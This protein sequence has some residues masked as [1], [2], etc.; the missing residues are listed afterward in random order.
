MPRTT[1]S[2]TVDPQGQSMVVDIFDMDGVSITCYT[3]RAGSSAFTLPTT[4]T[5]ETSFFL[6]AGGY[7]DVSVKFGSAEIAGTAGTKARVQAAQGAPVRVTPVLDRLEELARITAGPVYVSPNGHRWT[8]SVG[9]TGTVT[10][11][12]LDA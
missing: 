8:L 6:T 4:I 10:A 7:Y 3:A 11:A 2:I 9:N 5:E 1:D 12:D